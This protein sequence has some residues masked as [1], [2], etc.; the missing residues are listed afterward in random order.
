MNIY[1][2]VDSLT[3]SLGNGITSQAM[4]WAD[5]LEKHQG[6]IVHKVNPWVSYSYKKRGHSSSFRKQR[7][8]V[9]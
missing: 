6:I 1:Y 4:T 9:S 8:V 5:I 2:I 7:H 3:G